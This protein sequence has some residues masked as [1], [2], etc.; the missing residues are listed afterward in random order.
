ML[1]FAENPIE[2]EVGGPKAVTTDMLHDRRK[3]IGTRRENFV[4]EDGIVSFAICNISQRHIPALSIFIF[5]Q[6]VP[7][8][9]FTLIEAFFNPT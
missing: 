9:N 6:E 1:L 7:R 2:S 8:A 3:K 4:L 5:S